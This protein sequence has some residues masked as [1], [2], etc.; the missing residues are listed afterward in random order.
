MIL[1]SLLIALWG[2]L[3]G[4]ERRAFLQAMISRPL[5]AAT[6]TGL[7]LGDISAGVHIGLVFELFFLNRASLGAAQADHD[8]LPA[9]AATA[10]ASQLGTAFGQ[11]S[12]AAMWTVGIL[13]CAP[14]GALGRWF[15]NR[16]DLRA[17]RYIR[18]AVGAAE[19]GE[20]RRAGRQNLIAM[21][22]PFAMYAAICGAAVALGNLLSL[23]LPWVSAGLS[24]SLTVA[25][26][27]LGIAAAAIAVGEC[28]A[29]H[30]AWMVGA[31]AG[32]IVAVTYGA[33]R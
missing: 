9:V 18:L 29:P 5:I 6:T 11:P 24:R 12:N 23:A 28:R 27:G 21:W 32:I 4:L 14:L 10:L 17:Q 15:E 25:Y 8:T 30:R 19:V 7:L 2:G 20:L 3:L 33:L 1:H 13:L 26:A 31:A 16:L 22:P